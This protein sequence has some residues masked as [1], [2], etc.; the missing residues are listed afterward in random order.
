VCGAAEAAPYQ[1]ARPFTHK[2]GRD[3]FVPPCLLLAFLFLF[4]VF[5]FFFLVSF[6]F[7]FFLFMFS[8]AFLF[9]GA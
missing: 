4:P 5:L 1:R 2:N 6:L 7:F 9:A 8:L 3:F